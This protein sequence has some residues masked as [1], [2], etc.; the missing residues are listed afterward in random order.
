MKRET[1]LRLVSF[2]SGTVILAG[3]AFTAEHFSPSEDEAVA[4]GSFGY[5]L[6]L[7]T[8][9]ISGSDITVSHEPDALIDAVFDR[10]V[11]E[12][13]GKWESSIIFGEECER[14][15]DY[16]ENGLFTLKLYFYGGEDGRDC[17]VTLVDDGE[18]GVYT[19]RRYAEPS[20]DTSAADAAIESFRV[21]LER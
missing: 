4:A 14:I 8:G 9:Y 13:L 11:R 10:E 2:L 7:P 12:N 17:L 15:S 16:N 5:S 1:V 6:E 21:T 18:G 20:A 3:A 19:V